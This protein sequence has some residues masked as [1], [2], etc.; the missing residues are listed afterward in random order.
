MTGSVQT[1]NNRAD[2]VH[3]LAVVV[4]LAV[5]VVGNTY[6]TGHYL[7]ARVLLLVV[8][9]ALAGFIALRTTQ[10]K[11]FAGMLKEAKREAE[12]VVWPSRDETWQT[13]LLVLAVVTVVALILWGADSLF[14]WVIHTIIG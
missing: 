13:T 10:G 4:L 7:L 8:L 11:S 12:R 1:V 2:A 9:A 3:W 6:W 14:G 5:A